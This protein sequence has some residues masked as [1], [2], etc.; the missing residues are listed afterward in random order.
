MTADTAHRNTMRRERSPLRSIVNIHTDCPRAHRQITFT[1]FR[2]L[3]PVP[4]PRRSP[5][6]VYVKNPSCRKYTLVFTRIAM[7]RSNK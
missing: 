6:P 2:L 3:P 7:Q 5:K 1:K 4:P